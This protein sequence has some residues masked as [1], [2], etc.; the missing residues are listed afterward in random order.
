MLTV[1]SIFG[2]TVQGEGKQSGMPA[3]F[4]RFGGCNMWDGRPET[5]AKSGC[6]YCDTDFYGG[7]PMESY[8]VVKKCVELRG[9]GRP[10]LVVL[11]GGEPMLQ[12]KDDLCN[13]VLELR[14]AGFK[15]QVET[16]GTVWSKEFA[17]LVDF[18]TVSPKRPLSKLAA[19]MGRVDCLKLLY[20]HPTVKVE[21]FLD[22][23][24]HMATRHIDF[25]IQPVDDGDG[26][27]KNTKAAV[28]LVKRLGYPWRLSLQT[29]K[30]L[31][32]E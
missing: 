11:T 1:K 10:F 14:Q 24:L 22:L 30:I 2:I 25:C 29:H 18:V 17:S 26:D 20:P 32:E 28:E 8:Q 31:G 3:I 16:N 19:V 6:P 15:T 23:P 12:P 7:D 13:L 9:A 27:P 5:R 4:V 21:D